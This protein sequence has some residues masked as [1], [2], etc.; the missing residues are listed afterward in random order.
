[1]VAPRTAF[2]QI[3]AEG[4]AGEPDIDQALMAELQAL[5]PLPPADAVAQPAAGDLGLDVYVETVQR[6][7]FFRGF[8]RFSMGLLLFL[9][10]RI[11]VSCCLYELESRKRRHCFKVT[12][13]MPWA[14]FFGPSKRR[15]A[16]P[17]EMNHLLRAACHALLLRLQRAT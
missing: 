9:R 12:R 10:P 15:R 2:D 4:E 14:E 11:T 6:G 8:A 5:F 13:R 3:L 17:E 16:G 7:L 1:M